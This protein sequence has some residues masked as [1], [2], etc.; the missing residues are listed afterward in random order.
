MDKV[1]FYEPIPERYVR[2]INNLI[3]QNESSSLANNIIV[4]TISSIFQSAF[5]IS[6]VLFPIASIVVISLLSNFVYKTKNPLTQGASR[7]ATCIVIAR[8]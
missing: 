6:V 3:P 4:N 7:V 1:R 2:Y 8:G 5:T